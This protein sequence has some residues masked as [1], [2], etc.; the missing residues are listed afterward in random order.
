[1]RALDRKLVRDLSRTR[2]QVATITL[3]L[4]SGIAAYVCLSGAH[5]ALATS[6]DA[7]YARHAFPDVFVHLERAPDGIAD[8]LRDIPGVASVQTRLVEPVSFRMP[9]RIRPAAG[10]AISID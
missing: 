4:A 7:Y 8:R 1:M 6:R 5:R 3:I 2:A 9:D 10:R